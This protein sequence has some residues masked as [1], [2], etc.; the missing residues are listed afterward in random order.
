MPSLAVVLAHLILPVQYSIH[1]KQGESK[2]QFCFMITMDG[3]ILILYF[4]I[5][6]TI[7]KVLVSLKPLRYGCALGH[8]NHWASS[9]V[10]ARAV[11]GV[12]SSHNICLRDEEVSRC[13]FSGKIFDLL[14]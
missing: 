14:I 9:I 7:V 2:Y 13:E 10:A 12:D 6:L 1:R 5:I 3:A 4:S 8:E 11:V